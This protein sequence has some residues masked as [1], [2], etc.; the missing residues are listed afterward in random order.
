MSRCTASKAS[1]V[2]PPHST[3]R[4]AARFLRTGGYAHLNPLLKAPQGQIGLQMDTWD[5][6][7]V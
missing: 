4:L 2:C 5:H 1:V 7:D 3:K 6:E